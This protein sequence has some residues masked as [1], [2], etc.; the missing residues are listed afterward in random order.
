ML[1]GGIRQLFVSVMQLYLPNEVKDFHII[2]QNEDMHVTR[3]FLQQETLKIA[4]KRDNSE[5][6][7]LV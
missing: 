2:T 7:G 3:C 4:H 6:N 5:G 1:E